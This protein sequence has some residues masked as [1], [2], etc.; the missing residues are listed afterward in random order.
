MQEHSMLNSS[1]PVSGAARNFGV[2]AQKLDFDLRDDNRAARR[3][4][5]EPA[6]P[7]SADVDPSLGAL[8]RADRIFTAVI[9]ACL[10]GFALY[11]MA[12]LPPINPEQSSPAET[13]TAQSE[14]LSVRE[15]RKSIAIVSSSANPEAKQSKPSNGSHRTKSKSEALSEHAS[16]AESYRSR[17]F[18]TDRSGHR[19]WPTMPWSRVA[20]KWRRWRHERE[21]AALAAD[22][23][24]L[25]DRTSRDIGIP[26]RS[27]IE[28]AV[29]YGRDC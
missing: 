4:P 13:E 21:I 27:Q 19:H 15:R 29:R 17:S 20:S 7:D 8:Q 11:A 25:D 16:V 18:E 22:L 1:R 2:R 14:K 28:R 6:H 23:A 9:S 5:A 3:A 10:E 24:E 12:Y 26:H